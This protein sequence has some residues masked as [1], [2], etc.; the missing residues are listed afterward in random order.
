MDLLKSPFTVNTFESPWIYVYENSTEQLML[1]LAKSPVT[2]VMYSC[3][4]FFF[5]NFGIGIYRNKTEC[6]NTEIT[7]TSVVTGYG[8]T[9]KGEDYWEILNSYGQ[10]WGT[11]GTIRLARNTEWDK[12]GGQNG[13]LMK[14]AYLIP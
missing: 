12:Y 14:P 2:I 3:D 1:H 10:E 8:T 11:Q 9:E 5:K 6:S 7:H 13:I 4:D